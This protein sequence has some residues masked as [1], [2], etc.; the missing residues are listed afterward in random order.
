MFDDVT[1]VHLRSTEYGYLDENRHVYL[2]HT[3]AGLPARRQLAIHAQRITSGCYGNPHSENPT[4]TASDQLLVRARHAVLRHFNADP[5]EYALIFTPNATGACRL[6]GEAYPFGPGTRFAA[7]RR[8]PQ[9]RQR[10][11]GVR[12]DARRRD[13]V[14]PAGHAD[15]RVPD[16]AVYPAMRQARALQ[17]GVPAA[18]SP[19]RAEQL[20]RRAAP[21]GV[22][23]PAHEHGYDVLLDAAAYVPAGRLD[24]APSTPTSWRSAGTRCSGTPPASVV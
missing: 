4:S 17:H 8:Q 21:A 16:E 15:M 10:R 19:T 14:H 9:L 5:D 22:D 23:R 1:L 13:R 11:T 3:G 7:D 6:V 12:A 2:D 20:H 18:F 24:L